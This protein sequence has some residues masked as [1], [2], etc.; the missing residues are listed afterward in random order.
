MDM[1]KDEEGLMD[2][3]ISRPRERLSWGIRVPGDEEQT[4]YVWFDALLVYLTG[5]GYPWGGHGAKEN[6]LDSGWPPALQVI[7]KDII[8]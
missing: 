6:G 4:V 3:S 2:L 5:A 1:L 7:G 8:R